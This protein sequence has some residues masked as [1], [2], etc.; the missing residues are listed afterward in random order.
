MKASESPAFTGCWLALI[1]STG[2]GICAGREDVTDP[3][4][5]PAPGAAAEASRNVQPP[6]QTH[7]DPRG[8]P[9][10]HRRPL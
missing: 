10:P 6:S 5:A 2:T 8:P 1:C 3:S 7:R 9:L 4:P